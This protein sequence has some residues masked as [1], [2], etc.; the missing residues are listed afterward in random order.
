MKYLLAQMD[1]HNHTFFH[2]LSLQQAGYLAV[3]SLLLAIL[4][5]IVS[6]AHAKLP[7]G[8]T[9]TLSDYQLTVRALPLTGIT[10]NASGLSHNQDTG[11][12]FAVINNPTKMIE[13]DIHGQVLRHID[14]HGFHDTEGLVYLG[15]QRFAITEERRRSVAI[16]TIGPTT[17]TSY[18]QDAQLLTLP[19]TTGNN[20][21]FEG[22][23]FDARTDSLFVV[24]EK[25]PRALYQITGFT[26]QAKA[27][28]VSSL[29]N[30][31]ENNFGNRDFSGIHFDPDTNNLL[32]LSDE[33]RKI[34]E[35]SIAGD[36]LS[37]LSLPRGFP[38]LL[39]GI[40]QPE[41]IT[42]D[43]NG[44]LYILSE[45]NLFYRFERKNNRERSR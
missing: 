32:L 34:S 23:S 15:N 11:T 40:P 17:R 44:N 22:I 12:L 43:D 10:E 25:S 20:K 8:T 41:G 16:I 19:L 21:G 28:S 3:A 35:V 33:S 9:L 14:L 29:W 7:A 38:G 30:L 27:Q 42:M 26:R 31:E 36:L 45:P 37:E 2:R 24:N 13:L 1:L 39:P 6:H 4:I 18:R 5:Q